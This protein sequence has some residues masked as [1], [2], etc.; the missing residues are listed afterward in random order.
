MRGRKIGTA[1]LA[2]FKLYEG[3]HELKLVN[4]DMEITRNVRIIVR[5]GAVTKKRVNL[6]KK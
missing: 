6:F 3:T 4:R 1:P 5:G 2:A